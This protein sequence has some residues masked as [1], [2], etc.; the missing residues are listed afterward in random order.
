MELMQLADEARTSQKRS[1]SDLDQVRHDE[2]MGF[3]NS[4]CL[5]GGAVS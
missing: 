2:F 4:P 3:A 1:F 5:C